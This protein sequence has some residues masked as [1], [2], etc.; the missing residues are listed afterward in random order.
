MWLLLLRLLL[1]RRHP[2]TET[3]STFHADDIIPPKTFEEAISG[4][5]AGSLNQNCR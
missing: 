2:T 3:R 1:R 5:S 4:Q